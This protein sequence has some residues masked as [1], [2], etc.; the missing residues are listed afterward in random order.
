MLLWDVTFRFAT[1]TILLVIAALAARDAR[2]LLQGRLAIALCICLASMLANTLPDSLNPPRIWQAI[3]WFVHIP[4]IALLWLF[5]LSLIIDGFRLRTI[6]WAAIIAQFVSLSAL[7]VALSA[8]SEAGIFWLVI[9]TRIIGLSILAHLFWV[10]ITGYR[11]D[12]VE[13]RRRTRV[14]FMV[15]SSLA[16]LLIVGGETLQFFVSGA[17]PDP[18]WFKIARVLII[19]PI[20]VFSCFWFLRLQPEQFLFEPVQPTTVPEPAVSPKDHATHSRLVTTME[21]DK[22]YREQGLGIGDL[23]SK[24]NVPEHQLR[25]LINKGLG[26]RN[27]ASFLNRY[28]LAEAKA[29]LADPEQARTPI[30]TIAMDVGYASLATFNRAFKTE[31]GTTPSAFRTTALESAAQS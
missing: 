4:N 1:V 8:N 18:E 24:L 2:H 10:S 30:L 3:A 28:R 29:A 31:E 27:F 6:H 16:A 12:L 25:A 11:D 14:W 7:Q 13:G 17:A 22:L 20:T 26:Y 15:V 19:F 21:E 5:G 23:A 9:V